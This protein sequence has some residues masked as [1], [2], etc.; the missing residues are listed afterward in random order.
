MPF[1]ATSGSQTSHGTPL[2]SGHGSKDVFIGGKS[3]W[4][5][6]IDMH[7][8]PLSDGPKPHGGG[9]VQNGSSSV[10]INNLS[11]ARTGDIVVESG[12]PNVISSGCET[13][14]IG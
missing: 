13:V 9:M 1:A 12:P 5:A 3:A 10:F 2:T 11:A 14:I 8:C 4:R 6:G 7:N